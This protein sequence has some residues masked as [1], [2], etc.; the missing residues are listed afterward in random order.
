LP[1]DR[2]VVKPNFISKDEGLGTADN[3]QAV[4]VGRLSEEKGILCLLEAWRQVREEL[5][6]VVI[7][8]GPLEGAVAAS[9][10]GDHRVRFLGWQAPDDVIKVI[11]E[12][13]MVILPSICYEG[14]PRVIMEAFS[15]GVPVV[16]SR[17]GAMES[18]V[19]DGSNGLHFTAG[20]SADLAAKV[21]DLYRNADLMTK[22][23]VCARQE[24]ERRYT[25]EDNYRQLMDIYQLACS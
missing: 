24:Y 4:Y 3:A 22:M 17:V 5:S 12:S 13:K 15:R 21:S 8:S 23:R 6:L 25:A 9:A 20:D 14:L 10:R 7:G 16:A 1:A 18:L 2:I 19:A 11:G